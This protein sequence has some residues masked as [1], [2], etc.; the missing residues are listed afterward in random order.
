MRRLL[1]DAKTASEHACIAGLNKVP[2][3]IAAG[4]R[5]RY[6]QVI[7]DAFAVLP[8][9]PPPRRRN[10]GGWSHHDRDAWNLVCRFRD[11]TDQILLLLD[12]T[13]V[14]F[15][16]NEA[17]R[18]L[19]MAK[20]HDKIAGAFRGPGHAEAFCTVRSYIQT[21]RKHAADT[22]D[23]LTQLWTTGQPWLPTVAT[24][25]TS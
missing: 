10:H 16:N 9:G 20:L 25:N 14:S 17:E 2:P 6:A 1:L 13:L 4:I 24:T 11:Q 7:A 12:N 15:D 22:L 18:S 21:G 3:M 8:A 19:R 23:N 5:A